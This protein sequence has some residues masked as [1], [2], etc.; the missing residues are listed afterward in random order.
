MRVKGLLLATLALAAAMAGF[1]LWVAG[2]LP[3]GAELPIHWNA[4]GQVDNTM[5]ALQALLFP[6]GL[7]AILGLLF[8]AIPSL[9]P[10]QQKL[11]GSAPV[12]RTVWIGM[13]CLMA[14]LQAMIAGPALGVNLGPELILAG[15]GLLFVAVGN[16]LPK[17][18]PGFFVGIRTPWTIS[19]T[20]VWIATHRLGGKLMM[21]GGAV[22][23]VAALLPTRPSLVLPLIL[24]IVLVIALVPIVYSWWLWRRNRS[25]A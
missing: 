2:G 6:A 7:T 25:G 14:F 3:E 8:A 23:I 18:R 4:A 15:S 12:L 17:S 11:T 20:D 22:M 13:L 10:L 21:L 24:L 5:P 19:D 9:E 16:A 1:A